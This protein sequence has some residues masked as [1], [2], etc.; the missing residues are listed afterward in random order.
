[1]FNSMSK[2]QKCLLLALVLDI[3]TKNSNF[4]YFSEV[5]NRAN[6]IWRSQ[7]E[8]TFLE[9]EAALEIFQLMQSIE[10]VTLQAI[11]LLPRISKSK[12]KTKTK[13]NENPNVQKIYNVADISVTLNYPLDEIVTLFMADELFYK[14]AHFF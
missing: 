11:S 5:Y 4:S 7:G 10:F 3:K 6:N 8:M 12:T 1:M 9:K 2:I 13:V 14:F